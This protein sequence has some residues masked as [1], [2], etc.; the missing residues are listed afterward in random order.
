M[1]FKFGN[2][3]WKIANV[4]TEKTFATPDELWAGACK[5]FQWIDDNPYVYADFV[6]K[7]GMEVERE[8]PIPY[9]LEGLCIFLNIDTDTFRN[10]AKK[11]GY[12][13]YFGICS[14]IY[15]IIRDQKFTGATI[16]IFNHSIIARDLG[17]VDKV[18]SKTEGKQEI[19]VKYERKHNGNTE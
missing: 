10:Y 6:G 5:Y 16:G 1:S 17:L 9:T 19:I 11:E 3:L 12:G 4:G 8:K 7:D 13:A 15:D 14:R 2:Q 18:D